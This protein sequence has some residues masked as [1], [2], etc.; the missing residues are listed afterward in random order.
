MCDLALWG[1]IRARAYAANSVF[2][3]SR[4]WTTFEVSHLVEMAPSIIFTGGFVKIAYSEATL[5]E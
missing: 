2:A 5:R 1:M 3:W 4:L